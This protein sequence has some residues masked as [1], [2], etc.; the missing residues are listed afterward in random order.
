MMHHEYEENMEEDT[1]E[2]QEP[3]ELAE[4]LPDYSQL[5]VQPSATV[6]VDLV[7]SKVTT[8]HFPPL[9]LH[10]GTLTHVDYVSL[11]DCQNG[12]GRG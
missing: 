4:N 9:Y 1:E 6:S 7:P 5:N 2:E 11:P 3:E 8:F 12:R 10:F